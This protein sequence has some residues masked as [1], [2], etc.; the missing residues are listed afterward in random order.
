MGKTRFGDTLIAFAYL[1]GPLVISGVLSCGLYHLL[2]RIEWLR[3]SL[4]SWCGGDLLVGVVCTVWIAGFI[5]LSRIL[6]SA[7][8]S[9]ARSRANRLRK[10]L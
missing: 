4:T 7:V 6:N 10:G 1:G 2:V 3:E 9:A 8:K 5:C